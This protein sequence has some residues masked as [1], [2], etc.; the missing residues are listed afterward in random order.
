MSNVLDDYYVKCTERRSYDKL[1]SQN[2][3]I[4]KYPTKITKLI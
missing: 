3:I 2:V 4:K 1:N